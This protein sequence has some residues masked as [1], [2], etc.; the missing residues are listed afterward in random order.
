MRGGGGA[1]TIAL[2]SKLHVYITPGGCDGG[3]LEVST[4]S[5]SNGEDLAMEGVAGARLYASV[6]TSA[7]AV[8][9]MEYAHEGL[10]Y[11]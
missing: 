4:T 11:N 7:T 5:H 9:T 3:A 8:D 1:E 10:L 2:P 6:T